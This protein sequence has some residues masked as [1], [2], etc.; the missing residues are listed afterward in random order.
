MSLTFGEP[1]VYPCIDSG[2]MNVHPG[3][4]LTEVLPDAPVSKFSLTLNGGKRGL[5]VNSDDVCASAPARARMVGQNGKGVDLRPRLL[6]SKCGKAKGKSR[7][8]AK[9]KKGRK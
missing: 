2:N 8:A 3:L 9:K 4:R 6:H 5:L 1:F 7:N